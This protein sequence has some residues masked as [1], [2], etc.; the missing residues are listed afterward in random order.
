[1]CLG[2]KCRLRACVDGYSTLFG[3]QSDRIDMNKVK[4]IQYEFKS[5]RLEA[6]GLGR[7]FV[8]GLCIIITVMAGVA[9]IMGLFSETPA[10]VWGGVFVWVVI[11]ERF[12]HRDRAIKNLHL[13]STGSSKI[14]IA[15]Y[16]SPRVERIVTKAFDRAILLG[17]SVHIHLLLQLFEGR[18]LQKVLDSLNVSA[19][20][21]QKEAERVLDE[22]KD[23]YEDYDQMSDRL[24]SVF[25]DA[26]FVARR[27]GHHAIM[28]SDMFSALCTSSEVVMQR[29]FHMFSIDTEDIEHVLTL[30]EFRRKHVI[31]KKIP[32][33]TLVLHRRAG[34]HTIMNRAWT[35]RPTPILDQ[36]STDITDEM[37]NGAVASLI[38]H[39]DTFNRMIDVLSYPDRPNVLLIG[40]PGIGARALVD[41]LA[42]KIVRDAIAPELFDKRVVSLDIGSLL[43][44]AD[45]GALQARVRTI[46]DE[47]IR[48]GNVI[49][50]IPY[51]HDLLK[52]SGSGE[53]SLGE[54]II[55][56]LLS[57]QFPVIGITNPLEYKRIIEQNSSFSEVFKVVTLGTISEKEALQTLMCRALLL[58]D[59]FNVTITYGAMK[60]AVFITG[61]YFGN[62]P[63]PLASE[64]IIREAVTNASHNN[65]KMITSE[66]I[67]A[68]AQKRTNVPLNTT[69]S[70]ETETLLHFE[71][72]MKEWVVGQESAISAVA[73]ALREY[74]SGLGQKGRPIAS[75]LFVGPTGVGKTEVSKRVAEIQFGSQSTMVRI[76]MSEFQEKKS[77]ERLI[78][79]SD[80]SVMGLLTEPVRERPYSLILLDEFEK[81]DRRVINIFLQILDDGRVT[82]GLERV[83]DFSNTIIIATSNAASDSIKESIENGVD[84]DALTGEIRTKLTDTFSPELINR[85]SHVVVFRP[86]TEDELVRIAE[87]RVR[88]LARSIFETH[89]IMLDFDESVLRMLAREG[90]DPVFGARPLRRVISG[91]I[92]SVLAERIL[93]GVFTTGDTV[94]V[95]VD[96]SA[97]CVFTKEV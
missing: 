6:G 51:I 88:E 61:A 55:P 11:I 56:I 13:F 57:N 76:D 21:L 8:D 15:D 10:M 97:S 35:A 22:H 45:Q 58:E 80:G 94:S 78:G 95:T 53:A 46:F 48:A 37:R 77:V 70:H 91:K 83:I 24:Y 92:K 81:A 74:R 26:F 49:L 40:E 96:E 33:L 32:F 17:G 82:D 89:N 75:F 7:V 72:R 66:D 43:V 31:R 52:T 16:V 28:P 12:M 38:G 19:E 41:R 67:I 65:K 20:D 29:L 69:D 71:E 44:G 5:A 25:M 59:S 86:L 84:A 93:E 62:K 4:E 64:E 90:Y 85:F 50:C 79:S 68:V 23:T 60:K 30:Q 54:T 42:N 39:N 18:N 63:L 87:I 9:G 34:K 2:D 47:I 14:N 27:R 36:Y 3:L 1:M 73:R